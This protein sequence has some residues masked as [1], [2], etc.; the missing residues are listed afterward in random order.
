M[1]PTPLVQSLRARIVEVLRQDGAS[2]GTRVVER[3]L[4]DR[5][6][7]S[8]TPVR[9]AVALLVQDGTLRREESGRRGHVVVRLPDAGGY[10]VEGSVERAYL[11]IANDRL[12]G[13]L[14]EK[15]TERALMRRYGISPAELTEVLRRISAEGWGEPAPGY[16]WRFLEVLTSAESYAQGHRFR[17]VVEPAAL[18]EPGYQVDVPALTARRDEQVALVEGLV[19]TVGAPELFDMN[20]AFHETLVAGSGNPFLVDSVA[21]VNRLRR[22]LEYRKT[23]E[24]ERARVRCAEHLELA[25]LVLDGRLTEASEFLRGHLGSVAQEKG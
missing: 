4:A 20:A 17:R 15:A 19:E 22:L 24:P 9:A 23:L 5:L 16:G 2:E 13:S 25:D 7:V 6:G 12:D 18:L 1:P 11:A 21:R 14:A 8:R 10:R 3:T